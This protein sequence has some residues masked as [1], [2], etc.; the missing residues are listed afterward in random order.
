MVSTT[1]RN[2]MSTFRE[3]YDANQLRDV[4]EYIVQGLGKHTH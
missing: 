4:A 3:I 2:N 1:G